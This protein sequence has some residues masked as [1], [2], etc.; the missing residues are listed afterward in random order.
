MKRYLNIEHQSFEI[1]LDDADVPG[2]FFITE[3][4]K[5]RRHV[6]SFDASLCQGIIEFLN[7][8]KEARRDV[9]FCESFRSEKVLV[10][11]TRSFYYWGWFVKITEWRQ[12]KRNQFIVI[13]VDVGFAGWTNMALVL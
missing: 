8:A 5:G 3:R 4:A 9:G 13:L 12:D 11:L 2:K 6:V 1:W 10:F 7:N